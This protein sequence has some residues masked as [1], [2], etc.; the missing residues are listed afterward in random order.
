MSPVLLEIFIAG[1]PDRL[2][3]VINIY[4]EFTSKVHC[5]QNRAS[6]HFAMFAFKA[7][8]RAMTSSLVEAIRP[9]VEVSMLMVQPE[10]MCMGFALQI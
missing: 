5:N 10:C 8:S 7:G 6:S 1:A 4:T 3:D 2:V 9:K